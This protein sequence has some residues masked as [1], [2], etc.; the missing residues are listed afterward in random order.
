ML[1]VP[2]LD[3]GLCMC[4]DYRML[5][6]SALRNVYPLPNIQDALNGFAGATVLSTLDLGNGFHQIVLSEE[7]RHRF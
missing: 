3:G 1:Y 7:G 5:N 4:I 2:K 6:A